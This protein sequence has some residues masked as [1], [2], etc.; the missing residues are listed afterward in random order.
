MSLRARK[1]LIISFVLGAI[2]LGVVMVYS[3]GGRDIFARH[4]SFLI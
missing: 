4:A 3:W 1:P 2:A